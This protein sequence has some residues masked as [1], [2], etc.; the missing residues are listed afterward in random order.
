MK[1]IFLQDMPNVAKAGEIKEVADGYGRNFL[2][3]KKL[4]VLANPTTANMIEVQRQIEAYRQKQAEATLAGL[5]RELEGKEI[6]LKAQAGA[7]GRLHGS[8]T[9]AD[10]ADELQNSAGLAV[11][12]RKIELA[13]PINKL[14]SYDI[15]I[16]LSKDIIPT[17]KVTVEEEEKA[18]ETEREGEKVTTDKKAAVVKK[19]E[20]KKKRKKREEEK[21]E[22][23]SATEEKVTVEE[24]EKEA[25]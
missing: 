23:K 13:E 2:I 9:T 7:K 5:G 3:P 10:I 6:T 20:K 15:S 8:I 17:I 19:E 25:E 1:V 18:K 14:G 16:R 11:D 21:K 22:E 24:E 4:A 12:K